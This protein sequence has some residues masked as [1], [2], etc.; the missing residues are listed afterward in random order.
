M[1]PVQRKKDH[2]EICLNRPVG[3]DYDYWSDIQLLHHAL[4]DFDLAEVDTSCELFGRRLAAPVVVAAITGGHQKAETINRNLA[5]GAARWGLA[6]GVGSQRPALEDVRCLSSYQVIRQFDLPLV[7]GNIGAPQL[8]S[9]KGRPPLSLEQCGLLLDI[10]GGQVLAVHLNFT[11]EM[12]QIEGDHNA[13]GCLEALGCL[14]RELPVMAKE[15]GA[16]LS[17]GMALSLRKQGVIGLDVGGLG[18]TSFAAVEHHRALEDDQKLLARLGSTFWH[19][20]IPTPVSLL[21]CRV[22]L[23]LVATGGLATGL[24]VAKALAL[25]ATAG[26][27]ARGLLRAATRSGRAVEAA[28]EALIR[29]LKVAMFLSGARTVAEMAEVPYVVLG[30][31][32]NWLEQLE[33]EEAGEKKEDKTQVKPRLAV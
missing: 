12:V 9:Q 28:L 8:V 26:G 33:P 17:R 21:Q 20:G 1:V 23:P 5:Q 6:M 24:D 25:G 19:W 22:G 30:R 3:G 29:E 11:Q 13:R 15:T 32:A 7:I 2:I 4:P 27:L 18:G 10:I 16:G 14:A 31:T